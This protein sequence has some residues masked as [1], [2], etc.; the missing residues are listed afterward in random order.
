M[1]KGV[2]SLPQ[3]QIFYIPL[4]LQQ[5]VE[6]LRYFKLRLSDLKEFR[7]WTIKGCIARYSCK[8]FRVCGK[9]SINSKIE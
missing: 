4:S 1:Y 8:K 3:T 2:E 6:D 9:N 5:N 7:V